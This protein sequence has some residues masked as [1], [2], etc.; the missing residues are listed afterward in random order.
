[1]LFS[2]TLTNHI[3]FLKCLLLVSAFISFTNFSFAQ[4]SPGELSNAHKSLEGMSNCTKCHV[5]GEKVN[6]S[7]CLDCHK[8]V[9]NLISSGRGYHSSSSVKGQNCWSCH[10]E[11]YGRGFK[12]INFDENKFDH[13]KAGYTLEGSHK[14]LDC[15]K[16]HQAKFI[17]SSDLK[18][19]KKTY[20]GLENF[21]SACHEDSH[22]KTLGTD[23]KKCHD[24]NKFKPAKNFDHNNF[25]YKLTGSHIKVDCVKCHPRE[26]RNGKDFQKFKDVAFSSCQS[27]HKDI[28]QGKFGANCQSCHVT[29]SFHQINEGTFD[30][31]K[32]K[33]PLIGKHRAVR[34]NDCHK[35][36]IS[37]K[38]KFE[39]CVDC[40]SDYHKG[41]IAL[42]NSTRDCVDCHNVDGFKPSLFTIEQHKKSAYELSGAHF[43]V[44]CQSCHLKEDN[45]KFKKLGENCIDCHENVH[46]KELS[47]KYLPKNNCSSCH[48]TASWRTI[49]FD[50]NSTEFKL[51]GKHADV[52]CSKCHVKVDENLNKKYLFLSSDKKCESCHNDKHQGQFNEGDESNCQRCHAF[53][54]WKPE[55]FDH[56]KT[57]FSLAGAHEKVPCAKCHKPSEKNGQIFI[58]YKLADFKC[59]SCHS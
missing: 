24:T 44:P 33:Y 20:L 54:N 42:N 53:N 47:E 31:S 32:T 3:S 9:Q 19:R 58:Q 1:M 15:S 34:C 14:D 46:S 6:N 26:T 7:K 10:G 4:I 56:N 28:H 22:Q 5:L 41:E 2:N 27:C 59:A 40:H 8:A 21:C 30:H 23:C 51:S 18:K 39:K 55:N 52:N 43:A 13:N 12:L 57:R 11:H 45:W 48:E 17:S 29:S 35:D 50:H 38:P 16:C 36:G 37:V 49:K 25:K